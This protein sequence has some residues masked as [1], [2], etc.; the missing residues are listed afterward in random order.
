MRLHESVS[1][2]VLLTL[3][4]CTSFAFKS[5]GRGSAPGHLQDRKGMVVVEGGSF[6]MGWQNAN[7]DE[8]PPHNVEV[9][10]F[11]LDK[12][13]VTIAEYRACVDARVCRPP[14]LVGEKW[15]TTDKHPIFGITWYDA[16]KY[17]EWVSKR[18]PT[19]AEWEY[20][21]RKPRNQPF[22]WEG[23]FDGSKVNSRGDADGSSRTAPVGSYPG[24]ASGL[25]LLDMAGNVS[26]WTAD[27]Y[28]GSYYQ[29]AP[30]R[31]PK[32]PEAS[33][34]T[35]AVRG[36]SWSDPDFLQRSTA[37]QAFDPNISN[38]SVGFRC[39]ADP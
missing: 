23:R 15:E 17:C 5:T 35:K 36:G 18:L 6:M 26:E 7:P 33:T 31:N 25:G 39:A 9:G 3:V 14:G 16:Q 2:L 22:P 4:G 32:G 27:W 38:S 20:A 1:A 8:F 13:E 37:R 12:T 11:L 10:A 21:A 19:E 29:T 34:G 24:G 30:P 28:D